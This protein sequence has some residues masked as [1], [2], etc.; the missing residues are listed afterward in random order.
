MNRWQEMEND[1][2]A[3][4]ETLGYDLVLDALITTCQYW[5]TSPGD[6]PPIEGSHDLWTKREQA[7]RHAQR[8][9]EP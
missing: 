2:A 7:L 6:E 3:W 1:I 9:T 8:E 4:V 5:A